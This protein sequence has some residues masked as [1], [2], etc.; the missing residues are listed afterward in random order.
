M[1]LVFALLVIV[2]L[3]LVF[4]HANATFGDITLT[5]PTLVNTLGHP[6][7]SLN[8]GQPIGVSSV[9]TNH[10]TSEQKFTYIVQILN[11]QGQ[12]EYLQGFSAAMLSNQSFTA[13][14]S[15]IP[16]QP[17]QYTA[18]VFVWESLASA[19]PLTNVIQTELA[20]SP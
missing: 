20:V 7:T 18:Q 6:L 10:G 17:G 9:L 1:K 14:Q 4:P 8:V 12:T 11:N 15:W 5:A 19:I 2:S 16:K 13:A 3:I